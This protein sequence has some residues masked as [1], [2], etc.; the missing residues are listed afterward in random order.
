MQEERWEIIYNQINGAYAPGVCEGV[1]DEAS[2]GGEL[3]SL[4]EKIYEAREHLC[5]RVNL[6]AGTDP[7]LEDMFSGF[8]DLSRVCGK[9]MYH[10]GYQDGVNKVSET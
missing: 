4:V 1:K 6:D 7:D 2:E 9:L 8:E 3:F 5:E 10:H